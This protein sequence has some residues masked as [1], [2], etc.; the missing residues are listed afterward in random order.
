MGEQ[1]VRAYLNL[2]SDK[3]DEFLLFLFLFLFLSLSRSLSYWI[4]QFDEETEVMR[5][6]LDPAETGTT[7]VICHDCSQEIYWGNI[8]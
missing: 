1:V 3:I 6:W 7:T 4:N 5:E 8:R 2:H